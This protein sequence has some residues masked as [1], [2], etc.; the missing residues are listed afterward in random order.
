ML[1]NV[2]FDNS[3]LPRTTTFADSLG[4]SSSRSKYGIPYQSLDTDS[5]SGGV[6]RSSESTKMTSSSNSSSRSRES[7]RRLLTESPATSNSGP[8][9]SSG[10]TS[11]ASSTVPLITRS[12]TESESAR[13]VSR[14]RD[15]AL[16]RIFKHYSFLL[17]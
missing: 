3:Q 16:A 6:P 7:T 10:A 1:R 11:R 5:N 9:V 4:S 14:F 13:Y 8:A 2:V 17:F 12:R 15:L